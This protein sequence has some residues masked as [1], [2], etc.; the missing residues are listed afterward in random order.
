MKQLETGAKIKNI[1]STTSIFY[2]LTVAK[3][4]ANRIE[5]RKLDN[6]KHLLVC[7]SGCTFPGSPEESPPQKTL[8]EAD[9]RTGGTPDV[10]RLR[11][12]SPCIIAD[13]LVVRCD[14]LS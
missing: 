14:G 3:L 12:Q 5:S 8:S 9:G 6:K 11:H 2:E 13:F 7:V 4:R 10:T 1:F